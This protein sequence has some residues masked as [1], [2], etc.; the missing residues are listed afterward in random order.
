MIT[1]VE[2]RQESEKVFDNEDCFACQK[3]TL[4]HHRWDRW[5]IGLSGFCV[6]H[7]LFTYF[8][9]FAIPFFRDEK[10]FH[11]TLFFPLLCFA[12]IAFFRGYCHHRKVSII[13]QAMTGFFILITSLYLTEAYEIFGTLL[14][15]FTLIVA[16][17]RNIKH[18]HCHPSD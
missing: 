3:E 13:I 18:C 4:H 8:F 15:S 9:I 16:H 17:L 11:L 10:Q 2:K 1:K 12:I 14:G 5:A 7:C 6:I